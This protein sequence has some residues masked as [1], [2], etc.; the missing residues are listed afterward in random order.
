MVTLPRTP[1]IQWTS[2]PHLCTPEE[3]MLLYTHAATKVSKE[4]YQRSPNRVKRNTGSRSTE[5]ATRAHSKQLSLS[6]TEYE[7]ASVR[8]DALVL[9]SPRCKQRV[10]QPPPAIS[11]ASEA[12]TPNS[13]IPLVTH[14][15]IDPS[16]PRLGKW[17]G[18]GQGHV[19]TP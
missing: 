9:C 12:D 15:G 7:I 14:Y 5:N 16:H 2:L 19:T 4:R 3:M 6:D 13:P 8:E 10:V 11:R 1:T 17:C 18:P